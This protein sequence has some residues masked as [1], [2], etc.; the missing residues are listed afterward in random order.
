VERSIARGVR[1]AARVPELAAFGRIL[2]QRSVGVLD[3]H[4]GMPEDSRPLPRIRYRLVAGSLT[5]SPKH[6]LAMVVGDLLVQ[7]WSAHAQPRGLA[8]VFPGASVLHVPGAGHFDLLN[9]D[10]VYDAIRGWL[11][12]P[13][14]EA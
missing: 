9:H 14:P 6:P 8:G 1:M 4:D 3:L 10:D 12:E 7:P 2:E 11:A 13:V 5:R